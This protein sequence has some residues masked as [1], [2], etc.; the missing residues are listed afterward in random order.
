[1]CSGCITNAAIQN[2][3][4]V[5]QLSKIGSLRKGDLSPYSRIICDYIS[6]LSQVVKTGHI[7]TR[8]RIN[9]VPLGLIDQDVRRILE[10]EHMIKQTWMTPTG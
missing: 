6:K 2:L 10:T 7:V 9:D 5:I 8:I 1:M 3:N 4:E